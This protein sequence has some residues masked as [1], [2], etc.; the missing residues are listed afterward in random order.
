MQSLGDSLDGSDNGIFVCNVSPP[1]VDQDS[2]L[3]R[4]EGNRYHCMH[5]TEALALSPS[6]CS[7]PKHCHSA[8]LVSLMCLEAHCKCSH[9]CLAGPPSL[10]GSCNQHA[11]ELINADMY[12]APLTHPPVLINV[13]T[14]GCSQRKCPHQPP[15]A[16]P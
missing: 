3:Q 15:G 7:F 6:P 11:K 4:E 16:H 2:L 14:G 8:A 5:A 1:N 9:S 12:N 10:G 13:G